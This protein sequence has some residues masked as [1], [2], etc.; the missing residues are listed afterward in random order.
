MPKYT[1]EVK[2]KCVEMVKQGVALAEITR[3]LGPNPKAIG[4]YCKKAGVAM[5]KKAPAVKK[6]K[7]ATPAP[8]KPAAPVGQKK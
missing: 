3:Q 4:R 1:E 5:P 7:P 6:E 2:A 8:A